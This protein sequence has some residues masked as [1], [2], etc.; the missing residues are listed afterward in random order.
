[1]NR[2]LLLTVASALALSAAGQSKI[3]PA[4][5]LLLESAL[6]TDVS[7]GQRAPLAADNAD[8]RIKAVV[9]LEKGIQ[10]D[11]VFSSEEIEVVS[12]ICGVAVILCQPQVIARLAED[13]RVLQIGFGDSKEPTLDFARTACGV[14]TVQSGFS[15]DGATVS[16]DGTG[17]VAGIMDTGLEANHL[18]FKNSDGSSR[19]QRLWHM[20]GSNGTFTTY[21][22]A[23]IS[24]FET[25]NRAQSHA[26]HVA[27][28]MAGS[29]KG[30]GRFLRLNSASGTSGAMANSQPIPFYGVATGADL[31]LS[32][33]SLYT[34]NI[35]QGVTNIIEYAESTGQPCVV[36][37]SLGS[38]IGPHDG[39]DYYSQALSR[40][41]ERGII[42][43]SA[44]NEGSDNLSITKTLTSTG[45]NRF[46]RTYPMS[47]N[48]ESAIVDM[49]TG[50]DRP[51]PAGWYI[52]KAGQDVPLV[53]V[54][55][56]GQ[57]VSSS[58]VAQ[59]N[60]LFNGSITVTSSIDE[61]NGRYNVYSTISNLSQKSTNTSS[62]IYF[63]AGG[64]GFS[65]EKIYLFGKDV[66]FN[67]RTTV[68]GA[69]A[70]GFTA[71]SPNNSIN[72]AACAENLISVGAFTTRT[73]WGV[74]SGSV[75]GYQATAGF[76]VGEIAPFSSWGESFS[77]KALPLVCAP[78]AG[79]ISSFSRYYV[80]AGNLA[81]SMTGSA[82]NG[83]A[84]DYWGQ[85]QGTSMSCPYV[86]GVVAMWLQACPTLTFEQVMDVINNTS[87][88]N[89]LTM[90]GGRWGAGKID[91]LEGIR[92]ILKNY[93]SIGTVSD[94]ARRLLFT[95][96]DGGYDVTIAG[97]KRFTVELVDMQGRKVA[98]AEGLDGNA[99]LSTS[100]LKAGVYVATVKGATISGSE[101]I[102][103]R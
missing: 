90:R 64:D 56:A 95:P 93:S 94:D 42:C 48:L 97:E 83:A 74:L 28:I 2:F 98:S 47:Q 103:V 79:M 33:G 67:N 16:F 84:T 8:S 18:N 69:A 35:I 96:A 61:A 91:A 55:D 40:L 3:N 62:Y 5:R 80:S 25:D 17:V 75:M 101:K 82:A 52:R 15:H 31:A 73:T 53:V 7:D 44:G 30:N 51:M 99:S 11:E 100:G 77:G 70:A 1:M 81:N 29:Y 41:G 37:L 26:T 58:G 60:E 78:G 10:A 36:N 13:P 23:N 43:I 22:P 68:G 19:I 76:A 21:T 27:G 6:R 45:N 86:S 89:A 54:T 46:L 57:T 39:T 63:Q 24:S 20:N 49:W 59:F 14:S 65:G 66:T 92:Y 34:P 71:G 85:M 32:C 102:I 38:N 9:I 50:S 72:D 87:T 88:Y 4:G 12:E